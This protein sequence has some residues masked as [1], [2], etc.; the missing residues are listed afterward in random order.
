MFFVLKLIFTKRLVYNIFN[1]LYTTYGL[2]REVIVDE[3]Q[4]VKSELTA[5]CFL[6]GVSVISLC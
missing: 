2:F 3:L 1:K 4:T 6:S 5:L